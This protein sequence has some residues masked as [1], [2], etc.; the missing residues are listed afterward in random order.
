MLAT[1]EVLHGEIAYTSNE[2]ERQADEAADAVGR[3]ADE[4]ADEAAVAATRRAD[5]G[6]EA[7][8]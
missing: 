3:H 4:G 5:E 1:K 8:E 6:A 2:R 7:A